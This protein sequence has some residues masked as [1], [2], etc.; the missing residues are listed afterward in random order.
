M[1]H[2]HEYPVPANGSCDATGEHL[3]PQNRTENPP[4]DATQSQTC[5]VGDLSGK[6]GDIPAIPGFYAKYVDDYCSLNPDDPAFIGNRSL[7]IHCNNGTR[8]ACANW[9]AVT[10]ATNSTYFA[11]AT[12]TSSATTT[13][14]SVV[15]S[16]MTNAETAT[17]TTTSATH[18]STGNSTSGATSLAAGIGKTMF[19]FGPLAAIAAALMV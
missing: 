11:N 2:V 19:G 9:A 17:T 3:D 6:Y 8:L 7:V 14:T 18:S 16:A 4:C 12:T 1:Y 15:G 13:G 5:Q 10:N